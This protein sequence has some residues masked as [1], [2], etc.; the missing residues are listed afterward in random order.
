[1]LKPLLIVVFLLSCFFE[2]WSQITDKTMELKA[3]SDRQRADFERKKTEAVRI[4]T[5]KNL[6]TKSSADD[7]SPY[8]IFYF[9]KGKPQYMH[10]HNA[11]GAQLIKS[12]ELYNGGGAGLNL[13]GQGITLG[14]WDQSRVRSEHQELSGRV[15]QID[16][17][18]ANSSHAT[19]VAGTLAASGVNATAKGMSYNATLHAHDWNFDNNEMATAG[20]NGL[21]VSQHSYGY[22]TGWH[23]GNFS[24]QSGWH[25]FGDPV[26]D[27]EED[28]YFGY[29]NE[30]SA[31]W[32][33]ISYLAPEYLIVKSAGNDRGQGP[34]SGT[35][36]FY[37]DGQ[38]NS[39]QSSTVT[40]QKDGGPDGYDCISHRG[41]SKNI[42]T[43][44]AVNG[45]RGMT[46]FSGWGPT[47]DGRIKPDIVAKGQGVLSCNANAND[48]YNTSSGT[49]MSGPMVSGSIGL[50][51]EHQNNLHPGQ[52]LLAST[53]KGL[54]IHTADEMISGHPGPDYRFGWGL[55]DTRRAAQTLTDR[56]NG[57]AIIV[58]S[59][60]FEGDTLTY[61]LNVNNSDSLR[62]TLVWTDV[63]GTPAAPT[64]N[65][66]TPM[67]V[68]DL[69]MRIFNDSLSFLPYILDP[70][71]PTLSAT[72]GDNA[73][74]N[75]EVINISQPQNGTYTLR[76]T[77][78]N[79]I[80]GE[81]QRFS[82]IISGATL[83]DCPI[84]AV[85]PPEVDIIN[86]SCQIDCSL[87]GGEIVIPNTTPCPTGSTLQF[88]VNAGSWS[89]VL[90]TY[91][92]D[93]P[94]QFISTRCMCND[95][96]AVVS[97]ASGGIMTSPGSC[98]QIVNSGDSGP[99]TLRH[100]IRCAQD[101]DELIYD[102]S[103]V[104]QS[105]LT[106]ILT[107]DKAVSIVG[108][109]DVG[110]PQINIDFT[111]LT[112]PGIIITG[113]TV[114]LEDIQIN[115]QNNLSNEVLISINPGSLLTTK[116]TV[117]LED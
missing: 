81:A 60:I 23:H 33:S 99:G 62:A 105:N 90:P 28:F 43:V 117:E 14:I 10:T 82:L 98:L 114:T 22:I 12:S 39:W 20:L 57:D 52:K 75:I 106:Q 5:E 115:A 8:E 95:M 47:D 38:S 24:G 85:A 109:L 58:E 45:T 74:D 2:S 87:A 16:G 94:P 7:E 65:G 86:S 72:T 50:L 25:W 116:G 93:G 1:M 96:P 101:G 11:Q 69:D 61:D 108:N 44:G 54:I 6:P 71:Q 77:H 31:E 26:I 34:A 42:L 102:L 15:T 41:L 30:Y 35:S 29:Y 89:S 53:I 49:S 67:L 76:I 79:Q 91:D 27:Q 59:D 13:S 63:P 36:H 107:I 112:G 97:P 48:T 64:L 32:D 19:H 83:T 3:F 21:N 18:T 37:Y 66:T 73:R 84:L 110:I 55:M 113:S 92:Q 9:D 100:A 80:H 17:A 51:L 111:N 56:S 104:T 46:S 70:S 4:L 68:N 78:K 40:R 88:R 103:N